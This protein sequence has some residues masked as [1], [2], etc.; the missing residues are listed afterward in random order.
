MD[1]Q[2]LLFNEEEISFG[3]NQFK[4]IADIYTQKGKASKEIDVISKIKDNL[5]MQVLLEEARFLSVYY[6]KKPITKSRAKQLIFK[7]AVPKNKRELMVVN[8]YNALSKLALKKVKFSSTLFFEILSDILKGIDDV[9]YATINVSGQSVNI[10]K[11]KRLLFDNLLQEYAYTKYENKT[12]TLLIVDKLVKTVTQLEPLEKYNDL[13]LQLIIRFLIM[14]WQNEIYDCVSYFEIIQE[15]FSGFFNYN[16][17]T[18]LQ[19]VEASLNKWD[20]LIAKYNESLKVNKIDQIINTVKELP[21]QEISKEDIRIALPFVSDT[22]IGRA[23]RQLK[24][25]KYL[26]PIIKGRTSTWKKVT[27][28]KYMVF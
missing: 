17:T 4:M 26:E 19:L 21:E 11:S 20:E 24:E 14:D 15:Q 8:T 1:K 5:V 10:T 12:E 6:Y 2:F 28:P 9:K 13:L 7:D 23:L 22:T 25:E 16:F 3:H 27:K 18:L